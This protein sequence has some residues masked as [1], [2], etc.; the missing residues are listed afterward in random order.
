[1]GSLR[2]ECLD[3]MLV[4]STRQRVRVLVDYWEYFNQARPHQGL[5][6][7]TPDST[8][9]GQANV[10]PP[11]PAMVPSS[12]L[13]PGRGAGRNLIAMPILNGVHHS[14]AWAT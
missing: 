9:L 6:Q 4:F 14:Y 13:A 12:S 1:V 3:P 10:T 11:Q 8:R 2:R 5:A 7:Q